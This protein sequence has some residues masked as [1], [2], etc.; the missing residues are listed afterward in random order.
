MSLLK[1]VVDESL[2]DSGSESMPV[3]VEMPRPALEGVLGEFKDR[4]ATLYVRHSTFPTRPGKAICMKYMRSGECAG[5]KSCQYDHPMERF[6]DD[7]SSGSIITT[8]QTVIK[9]LGNL[10]SLISNVTP[11]AR[12]DL[13]SFVGDLV[14]VL[15]KYFDDLSS[16][17]GSGSILYGDS[18]LQLLVAFKSFQKT[19]LPSRRRQAASSNQDRGDATQH[20]DFEVKSKILLECLKY[21]NTRWEDDEN[22]LSS[23]LQYTLRAPSCNAVLST[24]GHDI[25]ALSEHAKEQQNVN[26]ERKT[27][28]QA[29]LLGIANRVVDAYIR[30]KK[31]PES[32]LGTCILKPFGSSANSLGSSVSDLDLCLGYDIS[33]SVSFSGCVYCISLWVMIHS[34]CCLV[35][36]CDVMMLSG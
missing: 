3:T 5:K 23:V 27:S 28:I 32:L 14:A 19:C 2:D 1:A 26:C 17:Y 25:S 29:Y 33:L 11:D 4:Y 35:L 12:F 36:C 34:L 30:D 10:C 16:D 18:V 15:D 24:L 21:L 13:V 31:Y 6:G 20:D 8:A 22:L 9:M 7:E